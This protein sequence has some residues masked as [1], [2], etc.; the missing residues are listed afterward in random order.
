M[1]LARSDQEMKLGYV[2]TGEDNAR[3]AKK[4]QYISCEE[5]LY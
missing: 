2:W 4:K 5:I 1:I 3:L